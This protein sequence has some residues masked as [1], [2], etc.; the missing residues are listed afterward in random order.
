MIPGA[1]FHDTYVNAKMFGEMVGGFKNVIVFYPLFADNDHMDRVV[2]LFIANMMPKTG[3]KDIEGVELLAVV[4]VGNCSARLMQIA[5]ICM[6]MGSV[7]TLTRQGRP[8]LF[9]ALMSVT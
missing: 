3:T 9:S 4:L 6:A 7:E 5:G 8:C 1:E 2:D